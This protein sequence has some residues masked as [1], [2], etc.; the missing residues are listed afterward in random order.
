MFQRAVN[1]ACLGDTIIAYKIIIHIVERTRIV[2]ED[3][4][5]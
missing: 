2:Q 1:V 4:L 3:L 5:S